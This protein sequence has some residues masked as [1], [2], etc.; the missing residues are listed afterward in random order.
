[1]NVVKILVWHN[2]K[3]V[4]GIKSNKILAYKCKQLPVTQAWQVSNL[5]KK[6]KTA[7]GCD[8]D[9]NAHLMQNAFNL[10]DVPNLYFFV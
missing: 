9:N 10:T 2:F 8:L 7:C 4:T 5:K 3:A 1:M 6:I